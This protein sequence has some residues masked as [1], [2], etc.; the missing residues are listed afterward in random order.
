MASWSH[1]E[2]LG[3]NLRMVFAELKFLQCK[4]VVGT[5]HWEFNVIVAF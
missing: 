3:W 1:G 4:E 2:C 5:P